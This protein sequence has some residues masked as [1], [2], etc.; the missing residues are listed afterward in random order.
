MIVN[1]VGDNFSSEANLRLFV[2]DSHLQINNI[3]K[4]GKNIAK[5]TWLIFSCGTLDLI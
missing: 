1:D 2:D 5:K 4:L 3:W